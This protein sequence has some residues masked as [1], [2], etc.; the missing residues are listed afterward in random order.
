M[1]TV[2]GESACRCIWKYNPRHLT[3]ARSILWLSGLTGRSF[4]V[5]G[6]SIFSHISREAH[7]SLISVKKASEISWLSLVP[8]VRWGESC[9]PADVTGSSVCLGQG[10]TCE[11]TTFFS[12]FFVCCAMDQQWRLGSLCARHHIKNRRRNF[13]HP[14][15]CSLN[16]QILQKSEQSLACKYYVSSL[17]SSWM[18]GRQMYCFLCMVWR[19]IRASLGVE[20]DLV[21]MANLAWGDVPN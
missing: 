11:S 16:R 5:S 2:S 9:C 18:A 6:S 19:G 1:S 10:G 7:F 12:Q 21:F 15:V 17:I 3:E 20:Q 13:S 8:E 14:R 4:V